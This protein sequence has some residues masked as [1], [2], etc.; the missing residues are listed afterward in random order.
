MLLLR[1]CEM[2]GHH[3]GVGRDGCACGMLVVKHFPRQQGCTYCQPFCMLQLL[4]LLFAPNS[5]EMLSF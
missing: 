2:R 4:I 3:R 1:G 5:F